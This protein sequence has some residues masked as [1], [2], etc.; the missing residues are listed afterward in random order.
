[1]WKWTSNMFL[2]YVH[3]WCFCYIFFAYQKGKKKKTLWHLMDIGG[4]LLDETPALPAREIM[5]NQPL[6][7]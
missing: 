6:G 2:G 3:F 5:K 1:M 7:P 4:Y